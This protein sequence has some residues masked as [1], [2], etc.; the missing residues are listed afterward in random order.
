MKKEI[1]GGNIYTYEHKMLDF[2]ANLN[3]LGMADRI[4]EAIIQGID[5]YEAYP[6]INSL[7][8][9]REIVK[10][11]KKELNSDFNESMFTFGNGA[12]DMIFRIALGL[13]PKKAIIIEP[14]FSEYEEALKLADTEVSYF[15][16]REIDGFQL[17]EDA[18]NRL[19]SEIDED[20]D[21]VFICNPNNPTGIP[22]KVEYIEEI[23]KKLKEVS[24]ILVV[25][26]CFMDFVN[27]EEKYSIISK[28]SE[29]NNTIVIKAFTKTYSMAGI[30]LGYTI[31]AN[32][33]LNESLSQTMQ[34]W[35]VSTVAEKAGV[36]ALKISGLIEKTKTYV[37]ENRNFLIG[38]LEA[39]GYEVFNSKANYIFFKGEEELLDYLKSKNILIRNCSNYPS[40]K[41]GYYRIAV[42][43]NKENQELLKALRKFKN[44]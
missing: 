10:F 11:Y 42:R 35:A 15:F 24:A 8:L 23:A 32:N 16:L 39:L 38:E 6:D 14:T 36:E 9:R 5:S 4:K 28:L 12:C 30:R 31:S 34:P 13:K 20:V 43:T 26:Q 19:I 29:L 40:L 17:T 7:A 18:K 3:P 22:V 25:D 44:K 2:S 27:N 41:A 33:E 37:K 1:H 21:M